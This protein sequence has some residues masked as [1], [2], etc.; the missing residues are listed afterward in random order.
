VSAAAA[1]VQLER[2]YERLKPGVMRSVARRLTARGLHADDTDLDAFYNQAWH[3]LYARLAAGE[4]VESPRALLV[5]IAER[6]AIDEARAAKLDRYVSA[7]DVDDHG[8]ELDLPARLDDQVRLRQFTQGLRDRLS[9]RE[10]QAAVLCYVHGYT[11]PAAAR[12]LGVSGRRMEKIMDRVS[13]KVGALTGDIERGEWC[14]SRRSLIKAYALGLLDVNGARHVLA[15][16]HLED[17][18]ACRLHVRRMRGLAAIAPPVPA[19]LAGGAAATR[20]RG[21]SARSRLR[22]RGRMARTATITAG[23]AG[24]LAAAALATTWLA[25]DRSP[26]PVPTADRRA[27]ATGAATANERRAAASGAPAATSNAAD[28]RRA[29]VSGAPAAASKAADGRQASGTP[30]AASKAAD[31]RRGA[32]SGTRSA[33]SKPSAANRRRSGAAERRRSG[34]AERRRSGA[35]GRRSGAAKRQRSAAAERRRSGAAE[36]QRSAAAERRRRAAAERRRASARRE[37]PAPTAAPAPT[38]SP[39]PVAT[40]PPAATAPPRTRDYDGAGEFEL[41]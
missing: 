19:L 30:A 2:D 39:P 32:S 37:R 10:R 33:S 6:R 9:E 3:G 14:E 13:K 27:A 38:S 16:A 7:E 18:P 23:A 20:P 40:A 21:R 22:P 36:R 34:A 5:T 17:C 28:G 1:D 41:R 29:A 25:A 12:A 8:V 24:A 11:R 35:E 15:V 26:E 31:R 4:Q